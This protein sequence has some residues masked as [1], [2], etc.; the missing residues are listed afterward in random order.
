M[1]LSEGKANSP[2]PFT[3]SQSLSFQ[4]HGFERISGSSVADMFSLSAEWLK[5]AF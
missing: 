2:L 1:L 5:P 3:P 4:G